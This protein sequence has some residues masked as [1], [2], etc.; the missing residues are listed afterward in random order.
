MEIQTELD[1]MA[2]IHEGLRDFDRLNVLDDTRGQV[3]EHIF[4]YDRRTG[5]LQNALA[6]LQ[7]L[8][9]DGHPDLPVRPVT[10]S[11]IADL[12][13]QRRTIEAALAEFTSNAATSLQLEA[14]EP[15]SKENT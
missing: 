12:E 8:Q 13:E 7:A 4:A 2:P 14:E 9:A 6:H 10:P 11:V 15:Q 1:E 3:R 5:L